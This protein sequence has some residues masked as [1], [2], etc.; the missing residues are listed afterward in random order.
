VAGAS[1][2]LL[3]EER[4][5]GSAEPQRTTGPAGSAAR[6]GGATVIMPLNGGGGGGGS[7]SG[8]AGVVAEED[9]EGVEDVG[10]AQRRGA[11]RGQKRSAGG[12]M[13][14]HGLANRGL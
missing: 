5:R 10:A 8:S 4:A 9:D 7:S 11:M 1:G 6:G 2:F 3:P 12:E 13:I 14:M